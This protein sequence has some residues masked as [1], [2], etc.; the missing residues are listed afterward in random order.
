MR[1]FHPNPWYLWR[2]TRVFPK[3]HSFSQRK[4]QISRKT[5]P[6]SRKHSKLLPTTQAHTREITRK[7]SNILRNAGKSQVPSERF[8]AKNLVFWR[9]PRENQGGVELYW[10]ISNGKRDKNPEILP[11]FTCSSVQNAPIIYKNNRR[12][13]KKMREN[14]EIQRLLHENNALSL[15]NQGLQL[16][17][18]ELELEM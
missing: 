3:R 6:I 4:L 14:K 18:H 2:R 8:P 16:K 1:L 9:F 7:S 11:V 5:P 12:F 15:E 10:E 13:S 17:N